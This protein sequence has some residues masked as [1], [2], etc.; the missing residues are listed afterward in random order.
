[1]KKILLSI[2]L[3]LVI[4]T[5]WS[6]YVT[7]QNWK[8]VQSRIFVSRAGIAY[9]YY[10]SLKDAKAKITIP[11]DGNIIVTGNH[12]SYNYWQYKKN[13]WVKIPKL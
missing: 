11:T 13:A 8:G 1:M 12:P 2:T 6:Q 7:I 10:S 4:S 5:A 3:V 9:P